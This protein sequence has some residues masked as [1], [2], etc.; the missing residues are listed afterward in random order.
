MGLRRSEID[1]RLEQLAAIDAEIGERAKANVVRYR[2][3]N[4]IPDGPYE[5]PTYRS[6]EERKVWVH[7]WWVRPFRFV[8][9]H[10]PI[11]IRSRIKRV[12]T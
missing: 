9:R 10:L 11:A 3:E 12:A 8:Y 2:A 5:F 1:A 7:K 4:G 6:A